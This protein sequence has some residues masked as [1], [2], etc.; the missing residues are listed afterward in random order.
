MASFDITP[1]SIQGQ[2][3]DATLDVEPDFCP[4]CHRAVHAKIAMS[5]YLHERTL[6]QVVFRCTHRGCQ[7]LFIGTYVS[8]QRHTQRGRAAFALRR[9]EP[10]TAEK[11]NF[12][13]DIKSTSPTFVEVY[14]QALAAES[15]NLP[16]LVGIGL[17]K[18]LEFLVK[19]FAS[20]ENPDKKD[21]I[22]RTPLGQCIN[23][24]IMDQNI[25]ECA[26]R[27]AW[28]GNDETHYVRRWEDKDIRDLKV[29]V[30]LTVNWIDNLLLTKKYISEMPP[31]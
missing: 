6:V 2:A 10:L 25:K 22:Q 7:E 28:L 29:L 4:V 14:D 31:Q 17:R 30:Q 23:N 15:H 3:I 1:T 18:S 19:D 26:K 24:Y 9:L 11:S 12:S 8:L 21:E 20:A 16:Q 5:A 27:A 13:D